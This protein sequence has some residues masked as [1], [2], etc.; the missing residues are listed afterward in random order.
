MLTGQPWTRL[1]P[2]MERAGRLGVAARVRHLGHIEPGTMPAIYRAARAMI[3]PSL[4]EGFGAPPLE[5][6]ACGCPVAASLNGS[7]RE[8]CAGAV[9]ELDPESVESIAD[10]LDRI[11]ADDD[12][13]GRL[14][15]AG[16]QR[17]ALFRWSDAALKH[18]AVYARAAERAR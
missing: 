18:T 11:V 17:A 3:F 2:L 16:T 7:L 1:E 4:Y 9:L 14:R 5:A 6:M 13:R 15:V 8:V 12:L 10:A